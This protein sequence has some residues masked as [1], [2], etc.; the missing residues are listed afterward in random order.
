[1][2]VR[3]TKPSKPA[4]LTK[5]QHARALRLAKRLAKKYAKTL[6]ALAK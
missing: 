1:M 4:T 2:A 5:A 6:A 3:K